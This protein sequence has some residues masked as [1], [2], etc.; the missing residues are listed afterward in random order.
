M[1]PCMQHVTD[2][3][4]SLVEGKHVD[5]THRQTCDDSANKQTQQTE[6]NHVIIES[7]I[8]CNLVYGIVHFYGSRPEVS[9]RH[10]IARCAADLRHEI[11]APLAFAEKGREPSH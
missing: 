9:V 2:K 5:Q 7:A 1:M 3:S 6:S 4:L 8:T 11:V 10:G